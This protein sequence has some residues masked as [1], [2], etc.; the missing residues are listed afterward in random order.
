MIHELIYPNYPKLRMVFV[1]ILT[2]FRALCDVIQVKT[3]YLF[4]S[5]KTG[6]ADRGGFL[7]GGLST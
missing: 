1:A 3:I 6:Y 5:L 2:F 4:R 7:E